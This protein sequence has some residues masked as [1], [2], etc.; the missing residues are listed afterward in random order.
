[1]NHSKQKTLA[2]GVRERILPMRTLA[3]ATPC[4]RACLGISVFDLGE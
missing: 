2:G 4:F 3:E 1:M